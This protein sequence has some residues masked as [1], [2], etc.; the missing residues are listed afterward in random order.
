MFLRVKAVRSLEVWDSRVV[1]PPSLTGQDSHQASPDSRGEGLGAVDLPWCRSAREFVA[2]LYS[3][4]RLLLPVGRSASGK[5]T[6]S[7]KF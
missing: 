3:L 7:A 1:A 6:V 4:P 5:M 2:I